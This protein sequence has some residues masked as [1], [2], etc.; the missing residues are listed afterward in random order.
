[1][2]PFPD[3]SPEAA[4][5]QCFTSGL[6]FN[7]WFERSAP[8]QSL[9]AST[10]GMGGGVYPMLTPPPPVPQGAYRSPRL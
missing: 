9:G 3:P 7:G 8:S 2:G 1:M 5:D 10:T 4:N 6:S